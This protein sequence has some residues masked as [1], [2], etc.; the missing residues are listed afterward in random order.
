M[1]AKNEA[2]R[3]AFIKAYIETGNGRQSAIAAGVPAKSASVMAHRWLR[4][5]EIA[6]AIRTGVEQQLAELAPAALT[7][8]KRLIED[9]QTPPATRLQACRDVL[10]RAGHMPPKRAEIKMDIR[11]K[12]IE[13]LTREELET[14]ARGGLDIELTR[15][16]LEEI[17][18]GDRKAN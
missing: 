15:E 7:A 9:A 6:S 12:P 16:K 13:R 14:I 4:N 10:D 18:A 2:K 8:I 3:E 11:E 5:P 1:A 17:A